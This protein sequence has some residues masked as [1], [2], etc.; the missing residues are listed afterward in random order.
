MT[1]RIFIAGFGGQGTILAGKLIAIAAMREG[2]FISHIP[3][4]GV[5]M[6]GGSANCSVVVSDAEIPSP[7]IFHPDIMLALDEISLR[8]FIERLVSGGLLVY[9]SSLIKTEIPRKDI[10]AVP[11]DANAIAE[12][13]GSVRA[14]NMVSIGALIAQKPEIASLEA[15]I[16]ALG[17]A[18]SSRNQELN[19]LNIKALKTGYNLVSSIKATV[20]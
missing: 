1:E 8:K 5:E 17:E 4:Y 2:K 16:G 18:V 15:V 3:N 10:T 7:L 20:S 13:L 12:D 19:D 14:A 6:R 11:V 9:N